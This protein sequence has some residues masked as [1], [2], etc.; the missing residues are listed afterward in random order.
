MTNI[1]E[2]VKECFSI[3]DLCRKLKLPT[4]GSGY[5]KAKKIISECNL[6]ISHFD[7]GRKNRFKYELIYKDCPVCGRNFKTQKRGNR[8]EKTTCSHSC[9]NTYFRSGDK[10]GNWK[11]SSYR[12]TCFLI[13]KKE[14]VI[15]GEDKLVEVHHMDE[16]NKNNEI[17][18]LIPLCPTHHQY[19]HSRYRNEIEEKVNSY[20]KKFKLGLIYI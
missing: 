20:I 18:N 15:C 12:T 2:I 7:G 13:H 10:N 6:D 3:S 1:E 8:L 5:T 16:N 14:C 17:E 9:S 19:W 11:E 4:G